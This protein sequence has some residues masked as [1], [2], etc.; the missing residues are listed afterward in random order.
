MKIS[1]VRHVVITCI[2]FLIII[3]LIITVYNNRLE[4]IARN[5]EAYVNRVVATED[6][7]PGTV[8]TEKNVKLVQIQDVVKADG[9]AYRLNQMDQQRET[10]DATNE[11]QNMLLDGKISPSASSDDKWV[12]GK[13]AVNKIRK[14]ELIVV[15]DLRLPED[16]TM[17]NERIYSISFDSSSTG[18]YNVRVGDKIDICLLYNDNEK[19]IK[20]YQ[21][22]E[23]NKTIDIVLAKKEII[24]IR[25]EAGNSQLNNSAVVPGY[26]CFKL[27]YDEINKIE[28]A[29]RQGKVFAGIVETYLDDAH[30]ETFMEGIEL[31]KFEGDADT[32]VQP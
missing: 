18:G 9:L 6:I 8:I 17:G 7:T 32:E 16:M 30:V 31:P 14:G 11:Y 27:T 29:K 22:L 12:V 21:N 4:A 23:K 13:T 3:A 15:D 10:V 1:R 25:D 26:I 5:T 28:L 19:A 20:E 2:I 24:D